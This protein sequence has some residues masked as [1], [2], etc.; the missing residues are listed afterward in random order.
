MRTGR[1]YF[2]KRTMKRYR[3]LQFLTRA[4]GI[5]HLHVDT[6]E[7]VPVAVVVQVEIGRAHV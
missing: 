2:V 4:R 5:Y 6:G 1:E 7:V 3:E